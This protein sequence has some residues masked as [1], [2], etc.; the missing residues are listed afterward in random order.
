M[1]CKG[2]IELP[3]SLSSASCLVNPLTYKRFIKFLA[4]FQPFDDSGINEKLKHY[5][6]AH[7]ISE[8]IRMIYALKDRNREIFKEIPKFLLLRLLT[9]R[10]KTSDLKKAVYKLLNAIITDNTRFPM[11]I[12]EHFSCLLIS[13][14][15]NE[16]VSN[17]LLEI[18]EYVDADDAIWKLLNLCSY[19]TTSRALDFFM[20]FE[21]QC[22]FTHSQ[23]KIIGKFA[24]KELNAAYCHFVSSWTSIVRN[25]NVVKTNGSQSTHSK[26]SGISSSS[27]SLRNHLLVDPV[28]TRKVSVAL[29]RET[30]DDIINELRNHPDEAEF[31][32]L[33][34]YDTIVLCKT[35]RPEIL[36][37]II[38]CLHK[39][40]DK[41]AA[42]KI[43][44]MIEHINNVNDKKRLYEFYKGLAQEKWCKPEI[45]ELCY[46][47]LLLKSA[48]AGIDLP[49]LITEVKSSV[50]SLSL[51][52][53]FL[54]LQDWSL[55]YKT[56][57]RIWEYIRKEGSDAIIE[58]VENFD[59]LDL[60]QR[61]FFA[62]GLYHLAEKYRDSVSEDV[63]KFSMLLPSHAADPNKFEK[64]RGR[65]SKFIKRTENIIKKSDRIY[66]EHVFA[67]RKLT[68]IASNI[69]AKRNPLIPDSLY[70]SP[71]S[72]LKK[73]RRS[74]MAVNRSIPIPRLSLST[75]SDASSHL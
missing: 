49:S 40:L 69:S 13:N 36:S 35:F 47:D 11:D 25:L 48:D 57:E 10:P 42:T 17:F 37:G 6:N 14:D 60:G 23:K 56:V 46:Q 53:L 41:S 72:S 74:S 12:F 15:T 27:S 33:R 38:R 24:T 52:S 18:W 22:E 44:S 7:I 73:I 63:Y 64:L 62:E 3:S 1:I 4:D 21:L 28:I 55:A 2:D 39:K 30:V 43:Y 54:T 68:P 45:L 29:D 5:E 9:Y 75:D 34:N 70:Y 66:N 32:I 8:N 59:Q 58:V 67:P 65:I 20:F 19:S 51:F 31:I 26:R 71:E 16:V 50:S 61:V